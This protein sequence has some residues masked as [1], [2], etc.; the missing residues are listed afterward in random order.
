M[1]RNLAIAKKILELI[2]THDHDGSG[3]YRADLYPLVERAL[4]NVADL[5]DTAAT[6]D[7]HL[8]LLI[9]TGFLNIT[10]AEIENEEDDE[11][12]LFASDYFSPTWA[13]HDYL[14]SK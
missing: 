13:G 14:D 11:D 7:Y 6:V 8:Y 2:V 12:D 4:Y 3:V 9:D 10:E 5:G 1:Q